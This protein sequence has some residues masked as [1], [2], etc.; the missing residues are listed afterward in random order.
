MNA[1]AKVGQG[2]N[3]LTPIVDR[4][5]RVQ[6]IGLFSATNY[7][8]DWWLPLLLFPL[9]KQKWHRRTEKANRTKDLEVCHEAVLDLDVT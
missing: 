7:L 1:I 4:S 2:I 5:L 3:G 9:D 8:R 6:L